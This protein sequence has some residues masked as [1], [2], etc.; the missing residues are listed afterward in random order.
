MFI[1]FV[2]AFSSTGCGGGHSSLLQPPNTYFT[3]TFDSNGGSVVANQ[4]VR[5]GEKAVEPTAP[6]KDGYTFGGWYTD[7]A[8]TERFSFNTVITANITLYAKWNATSVTT[9]TVTFNSNGG[10]E[11]SNQNVVAGEQA[12]APADPTREG[13]NFA[14]WYSDSALT[15]LFSFGTAITGNLTLYAKW[16]AQ[17]KPTNSFT[18][19][20]DSNGGSEIEEQIIRAGGVVIE[21]DE[22]IK[23]GHVFLRW[24]TDD[25]NSF[26]FG[27][28]I[29]EDVY[30]IA[31]WAETIPATEGEL[32][33]LEKVSIINSS[34]LSFDENSVLN[35]VEVQYKL[36][37]FGLVSVV[38]NKNDPMCNVPGLIGNPIEISLT[39][40]KL[41]EAKI[42]FNYD[43]AKLS[44][45]PEDLAIIWY[46]DASNDIKVFAD[47][48]IVDIENHTLSISTTH[49]S[50]YGVVSL[51]EW[52][53]SLA[54][55]LPTVRTAK[56][57]YNL[58]LV[59]D[60]S[61]S[62]SGIKMQ[63]TII[64]AQSLIDS[65][66]EDDYV[67]IIA[68]E[69]SAR[70][71]LGRTKVTSSNRQE[72]KNKI[73][74]LYASGGTNF[75]RAL[76]KALE[77]HVDEVD[78]ASLIVLLSDGE[79]SVSSSTIQRL[80]SNAIRVMTVGLG[81]SSYSSY[82]A[83]NLENIALETGGSYLNA[84]TEDIQE[85]FSE[86]AEYDLGTFVDND[87]DGI[88]DI[89]EEIGMRDQYYNIIKTT[90]SDQDTDG[91]GISD[92]EEMGTYVSS[93]TRF[94]RKSNPLK[95]THKVD[96]F[97]LR[98][99]NSMQHSF[100]NGNKML[101]SI[102][103]LSQLYWE[104]DTEDFIFRPI[105][106]DELKV[107]LTSIPSGFKIEQDVRIT[108]QETADGVLLT[109]S[110][111]LS[112]NKNQVTELDSV[113]W[114]IGTD[115][116]KMYIET[117]HDFGGIPVPSVEKKQSIAPQQNKEVQIDN[118][119]YQSVREAM[120]KVDK[121][122]VEKFSDEI[123]ADSNKADRDAE[124]QSRLNT[125][126]NN[127]KTVGGGTV[128]KN[129]CQA[130]GMAIAEAYDPDGSKV[131]RYSA[132]PGELTKQ[133]VN[134]IINSHKKGDKY[135]TVNKVQYRVHY[136]FWEMSQLTGINSGYGYSTVY[137]VGEY[138]RD[139]RQ[140]AMLTWTSSMQEN[141]EALASYS[142]RL[143]ELNKDVWNEFL[144]AYVQDAFSLLD[145]EVSRDTIEKVFSIAEKV[146][147]A[148]Y[149]DKNAANELVDEL[150]GTVKDKLT[151]NPFFFFE[152]SKFQEFIRKHCSQ[153]DTVI[154][155]ANEL[156]T[157]KE[158]FDDF[159]GE[160]EGLWSSLFP[161]E[162]NKKNTYEAFKTAY[163]E[164]EKI[165]IE[166]FTNAKNYKW[167]EFY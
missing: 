2:A 3:V 93:T 124:L 167:P 31:Q 106:A 98:L 16:E 72:I 50:K 112:Y 10:T 136:D 39:G 121:Y 29:S 49:F 74:T 32:K 110:A 115:G 71:V 60:C 51:K 83:Q 102:Q 44:T 57:H 26:I 95:Y 78:S 22:P 143:A 129:V 149:G 20:F 99:P 137:V 85:K 76:Q 84:S 45:T 122:F 86:I 157:V 54:Q 131:E 132:Q 24:E 73:G 97:M 34:P 8:L 150:F 25:G 33:N 156:K 142:A 14:G 154:K 91:D 11:V 7:S 55:H 87:N 114:K 161:N 80:K 62:M 159:K 69:S 135:V 138:Y 12:V 163:G 133:I 105:K 158:K 21:P 103:M 107:E 155:T 104:G 65:M 52:K 96:E 90:S 56:L 75:D 61:G 151:S 128:D 146:I 119:L 152:K 37:E 113:Q 9:Y 81:I 47:E 59:I 117:L 134:E 77:Y 6:T 4:T 23:D 36:D 139:E 162:N 41:N 17:S 70:E 79:S 148:L 123:E 68:F 164:L 153:G 126:M 46:N 140:V 27:Y 165:E 145:I 111:I 48:S 67:S 35:S 38:E 127:I 144:Y 108:T 5:E 130:F 53:D 141:A 58:I 15:E 125:V 42:I 160:M 43:P 63:N 166:S 147:N 30:L 109:A 118:A 28:G 1:L 64:S 101:I 40:G 66:T 116:P 18:V 94:I 100:T 120:A 82:Y 13:Y 19:T 89:V 92:S 88:P